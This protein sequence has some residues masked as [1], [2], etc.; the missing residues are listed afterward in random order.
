[1]QPRL[2]RHSPRRRNGLSNRLRTLIIIMQDIDERFWKKVHLEDL[3]FSENGCMLWIGAKSSY[4]YGIFCADGRTVRAHRWLYERFHGPIPKG[5]EPDHLCRVRS[6]VNPDHLELVTRKTNLNRGDTGANN[7]LK[8]HCPQ[9][10]PYTEENIIKI[11]TGR[12]CKI[13]HY[14]RNR[15]RYARQEKAS[16]TET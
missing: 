15:E 4:G 11:P 3:I 10:H 2:L 9:G 7:R 13:C 6:C 14:T 5:L 12:R 16:S 8:T 1:M